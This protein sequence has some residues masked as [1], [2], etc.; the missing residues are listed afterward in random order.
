[1]NIENPDSLNNFSYNEEAGDLKCETIGMH[2]KKCEV[3]KEHFKEKKDGLYF[4]KH[5]NHLDK[6]SISYEIAPMEII[7]D[8]DDRKTD[9]PSKG[10]I[11]SLSLIYSLVLFLFMI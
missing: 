1:M 11:I 7:L 10:N 2:L 4:L 3:T 5:K 8:S 6:K 9:V